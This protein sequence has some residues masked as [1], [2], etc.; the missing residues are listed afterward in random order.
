MRIHCWHGHEAFF[1]VK[2]NAQE[3]FCIDVMEFARSNPC[4]G[5]INFPADF[6]LIALV[7]DVTLFANQ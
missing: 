3:A 1:Y 6:I 7:N 5:D 2:R 4:Q